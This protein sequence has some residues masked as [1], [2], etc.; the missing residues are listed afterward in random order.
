MHYT[1]QTDT[2]RAL[3]TR[4]PSTGA[5]LLATVSLL[6]SWWVEACL[7][8]TPLALQVF[9]GAYQCYQTAVMLL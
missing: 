6:H 1:V 5:S 7:L 8:A 9:D 3:E 2:L 4:P